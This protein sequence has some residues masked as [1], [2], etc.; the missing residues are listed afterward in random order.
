M[1]RDYSYTRSGVLLKTFDTGFITYKHEQDGGIYF[2]DIYSD[3]DFR[4]SHAMGK[5]ILEIEK[6]FIES[7]VKCFYS[8]VDLTDPNSTNMLRHMIKNNYKL[9]NTDGTLLYVKKEV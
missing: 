8:S 3:P 6:I 4:D 9:H 1:W 7:G 2:I 5:Q